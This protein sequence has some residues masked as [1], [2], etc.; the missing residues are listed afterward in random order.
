MSKKQATAGTRFVNSDRKP[1]RDGIRALSMI[2]RM[3]QASKTVKGTTR[4][5]PPNVLGDVVESVASKDGVLVRIAHC[6]FTLTTER[7]LQIALTKRTLGRPRAATNRG[8]PAPLPR[9][10]HAA[11]TAFARAS[12]GVPAKR[13]RAPPRAAGASV[14]EREDRR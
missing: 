10:R 6:E 8:G 2:Y 12:A 3:L 9:R 13:D 5:R 7:R 1:K 14:R 4:R 11:T